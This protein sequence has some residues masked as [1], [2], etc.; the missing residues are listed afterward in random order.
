M[1]PAQ[2]AAGIVGKHVRQRQL[3]QVAALVLILAATLLSP[4]GWQAGA[5]GM[6]SCLILAAKLS[7]R[8]WP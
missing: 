4:L 6:L 1:T 2:V 7:G 8:M 3:M 5:I